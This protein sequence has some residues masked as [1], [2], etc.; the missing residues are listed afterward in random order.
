VHYLIIT[1]NY[2]PEPTGIGLYSTDLAQTLFSDGHQVSVLTTLPHYPWWRVPFEHSNIVPGTEFHHGILVTRCRNYIPSKF[3][4]LTRAKYELS[5]LMNFLP[6][7]LKAKR[8]KIDFIVAYTP[9][10]ACAIMGRIMKLFFRIP[11]GIIVQDLSGIGASQSGLKGGALASKIAE[12]IEIGIISKANS[13]VTIS[14]SMN[15]YLIKKKIKEC[16]IKLILNYSTKEHQQIEIKDARKRIDVEDSKFLLLHAGNMGS[17]QDLGNIVQAARILE[18]RLEVQIILLGNGNQEEFL[19]SMIGNLSNISIVQTVDENLFAHYLAAADV[20]IVNERATQ[21]DMSLPSK[22]TTYFF[23][24]KPI[25]AAVSSSGATAEYIGD[26]AYVIK[27]NEPLEFAD[28]V[29]HLVGHPALRSDLA[30]R[31]LKFAKENLLPEVGRNFYRKWLKD[32]C[33]TIVKQ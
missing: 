22:L 7:L 2:F 3:N 29:L 14:L 5:I 12:K 26:K 4:V 28:A 11:F 32:V 20:L 31:G 21:T 24:R 6:I 17:K 27:P 25:L 33:L 15:R 18:S 13:V 9:T 10:L 8:R 1:S 19:K 16:A 23:S 30:D